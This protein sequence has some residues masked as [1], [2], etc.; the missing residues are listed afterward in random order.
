[1]V[2]LIAAESNSVVELEALFFTKITGNA[3]VE[4][5]PISI[6][7]HLDFLEKRTEILP[8]PTVRLT[9][10]SFYFGDR[11]ATSSKINF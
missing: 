8:G 7:R 10:R 9:K 11:S 2:C 1:M 6:L 5:S 3:E 4:S